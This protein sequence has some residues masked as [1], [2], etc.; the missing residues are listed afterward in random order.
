MVK[1]FHLASYNRA[2][3]GGIEYLCNE[4]DKRKML[5]PVD[6]AD[7]I[8][9]VGDRKET[10]EVVY[11]QWLLGFPIIHLWAGEVDASWSTKDEVFRHS[12][13]LMSMMQLCINDTALNRVHDLCLAVGK[14]DNAFVVGNVMLD[15][16]SVDESVVP[17]N[18]YVLVLYNPP[19]LLS[20]KQMQDEID[21]VIM[22]I[23]QK[24]VKKI[25]WIEPNGDNGSSLISGY[26]NQSNLPR[27][28]F[29][30]LLKNCNFY[31]TNSSSQYH[32]AP[33]LLSKDKIISVGFRNKDRDSKYADM[34]QV[35]ATEKIIS[36]LEK[37]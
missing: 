9:A 17:K 7:Y 23:K 34:S 14:K 4:L 18:P 29:L 37:L 30:G 25:I 36:L 3:D 5:K 19:T 33:F 10:Y 16:L 24:H 6:V 31:I 21:E 26:V 11:H 35:G 12:I 13:T 27:K 2:S 20:K 28:Q 22:M 32:E 15:D 1:T 8:I